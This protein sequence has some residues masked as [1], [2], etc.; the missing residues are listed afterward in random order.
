MESDFRRKTAN[1]TGAIA[2]PTYRLLK[3]YFRYSSCVLLSHH[4][5]RAYPE[6]IRNT[7][8]GEK[9]ELHNFCIKSIILFLSYNTMLKIYTKGL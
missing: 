7:F 3:K 5:V 6:T 2:K 8:L 1:T 4:R 9:K